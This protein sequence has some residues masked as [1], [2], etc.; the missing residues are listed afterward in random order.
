MNLHIYR[1]I[2]R[3]QNIVGVKERNKVA[4]QPIEQVK[5]SP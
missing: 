1:N 3:Q 2:I 4:C 5:R